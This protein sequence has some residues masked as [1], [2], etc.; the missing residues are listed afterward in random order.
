MKRFYLSTLTSLAILF[1]M[2]PVKAQVLESSNLKIG[3]KSAGILQF[4]DDEN[5][6]NSFSDVPY[7]LQSAVGNLTFDANIADGI[8]VYFDLYLSSTHHT[9]EVTDHEGYIY[10][11]HLPEDSDPLSFNRIF[12][13]IDIKA[14]HFELDFGNQHLVRSDNADVQRNPLIGNYIVDANTVSPA[15]EVIGRPDPFYWVGGFSMG[16]TTGDFKKNRGT[17][18]YGK[19]GLDYNNMLNVAGSYYRVD[20]SKNPTGYPNNG[21]FSS[22][23]SGNRSG[24]RYSG[25]LG[26]GAEPGQVKPGKGQDETAWHID[27]AFKYNQLIV[28]GLYGFVKDADTNGSEDGAPEEKWSYYGVEAKFNLNSRLY[29]AGRYNAAAAHMLNDL[30][31][32]GTV[33]RI[34]VGFGAWV[35]PGMLIKAEYVNHKTKDFTTTNLQYDPKFSGFLT[36]VSISF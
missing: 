10:L 13:Y 3:F 32:D 2:V 11:S 18:I 5:T 6:N 27:A 4:L 17:A 21:S 8:D 14:G 31:S 12:K 20:H 33:S 9:G 1:L 23:F 36:E 28:S 30:D 25:V 7:G 29:V 26:G 24:G 19:V 34:Q 22:L 35:V 15:I 16:T